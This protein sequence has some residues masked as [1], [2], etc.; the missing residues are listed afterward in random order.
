MNYGWKGTIQNF[1]QLDLKNFID[2][3]TTYVYGSIHS[4]EWKEEYSKVVSQ[5][6]AWKDCFEKLQVI[7]KN[8]NNLEGWLIFE[9]TILRGSGRRPDVLLFLPGHVLVIECKSY[10]TVS[11]A[12]YLQTSLYVRDIEHY[13]STIQQ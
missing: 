10:N 12:K 5:Q 13:H 2:T 11:T 3:L 6:K 9:Y 4:H 7:I 8:Y 1:S